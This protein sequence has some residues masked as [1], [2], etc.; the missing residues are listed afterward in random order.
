[1]PFQCYH[2]DG[3]GLHA[4]NAVH[5]PIPTDRELRAPDGGEPNVQFYLRGVTVD[6][7]V[8]FALFVARCIPVS[9]RGVTHRGCRG[10][11]NEA[12]SGQGP[13]PAS[14]DSGSVQKPL[15]N[16]VDDVHDFCK[17]LVKLRFRDFVW[18]EVGTFQ[19]VGRNT[20]QPVVGYTTI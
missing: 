3:S 7:Y 2:T 16:D 6:K 4:V 13:A 12:A 5:A 17:I 9:T 1:M 18:A 14:P 8:V 11:D 20:F 19:P 15:R 10:P